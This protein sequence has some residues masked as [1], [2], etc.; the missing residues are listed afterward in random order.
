[1]LVMLVSPPSF[2]AHLYEVVVPVI[3]NHLLSES[4]TDCFP[5]SLGCIC[6]Y[7]RSILR[8]NYVLLIEN[9]KISDP[10]LKFLF[11]I[12]VEEY[13]CLIAMNCSKC[14]GLLLLKISKIHLSCQIAW[15]VEQ[16]SL[17]I[18][19]VHDLS[20]DLW[21]EYLNTDSWIF[22]T[23]SCGKDRHIFK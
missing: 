21:H 2:P 14:F 18:L 23:F 16:R 4:L 1:M 5:S 10:P 7:C 17:T 9:R 19:L 12:A 13:S 3:S 22:N 8:L 6:S 15:I 20:S 11:W